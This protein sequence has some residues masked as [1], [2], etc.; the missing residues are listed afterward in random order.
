[1]VREVK[2]ETGL[3]IK[4]HE[5]VGVYSDPDRDP[6]GHMVTICFL[7]CR[8]AGEPKADTD[9][10]EVSGFTVEEALRMD[11]AFDHRKILKDALKM[12]QYLKS[13]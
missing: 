5:L 2:E 7:A 3:L 4:I 13:R 9:A 12:S 10:E 8:T 11:L 6:R 1:M